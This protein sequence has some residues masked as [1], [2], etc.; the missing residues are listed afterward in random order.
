MENLW[1]VEWKL[2]NQEKTVY[3]NNNNNDNVS[4]NLTSYDYY[5]PTL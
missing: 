2:Y 1:Y 3:Y 5:L 4:T